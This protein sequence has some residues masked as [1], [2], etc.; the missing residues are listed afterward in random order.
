MEPIL[1]NPPGGAVDI[2]EKLTPATRNQHYASVRVY[3]T[4][5]N[6]VFVGND[7]KDQITTLTIAGGALDCETGLD[8]T[9]LDEDRFRAEYD[10]RVD[11]GL[12]R[13]PIR[14]A[15]DEFA[16]VSLA[17]GQKQFKAAVSMTIPYADADN[18]EW[19][20]NYAIRENQLTPVLID[21]AGQITEL[22]YTSDSLKNTFTVQLPK[23]GTVGLIAKLSGGGN[24]AIAS[25][26]PTPRPQWFRTGIYLRGGPAPESVPLDFLAPPVLRQSQPPVD[27]FG[28]GDIDS[29]GGQI[30][31]YGPSCGPFATPIETD[32][33][34]T[35][36]TVTT[37]AEFWLGPDCNKFALYFKV[38]ESGTPTLATP[39]ARLDG[40]GEI[41]LTVNTYNDPYPSCSGTYNYTL[42]LCEPDSTRASPAWLRAP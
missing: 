17:S 30:T 40:Y 5:D 33:E 3:A 10:W 23:T 35:T 22:A 14:C 1:G 9:L 27:P 2:E 42:H 37:C 32:P 41:H 38:G 21:D 25:A 19:V 7:E 18:D 34:G 31:W 39:G 11:V 36:E 6:E 24:V 26:V 20:D 28:W 13:D 4:L 8:V 16:L 15:I 29:V 12:A